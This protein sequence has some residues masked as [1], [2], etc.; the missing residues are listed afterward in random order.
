[1]LASIRRSSIKA[2]QTIVLYDSA[3]ES[4]RFVIWISKRN[5]HEDV[6]LNCIHKSSRRKLGLCLDSDYVAYGRV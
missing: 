4:G 5:F 6:L 1:M 2:A 3:S